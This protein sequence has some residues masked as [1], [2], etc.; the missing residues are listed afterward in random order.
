MYRIIFYEHS[1]SCVLAAVTGAGDRHKAG[2]D[3]RRQRG[4][5]VANQG[6]RPHVRP[7]LRAVWGVWVG[8]RCDCGA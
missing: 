4:V 5:H 3:F 6:E 8:G 2:V 7:V 1:R